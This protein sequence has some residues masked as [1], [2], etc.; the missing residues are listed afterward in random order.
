MTAVMTRK[1]AVD[2]KKSPT[3]DAVLVLWRKYEESHLD[4]DRNRLIEHYLPFVKFLATRICL[5]LPKNIVTYLFE[6][7]LFFSKFLKSSFF[8]RAIILLFILLD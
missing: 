6:S 7:F 5:R 3:E 1:F 8:E 2:V 4:T